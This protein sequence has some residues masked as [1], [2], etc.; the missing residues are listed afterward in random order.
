[1]KNKFLAPILCA[2]LATCALLPATLAHAAEDMAL[3]HD[4][5]RWYEEDN[6]P[7]ARLHNLNKETAAAYAEAL[8]ACRAMSGEQAATCRKQAVQA[9]QEDAARA[10]RIYH[11]YK[12]SLGQADKMSK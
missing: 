4:P 7:K 8:Q 10:L 2:L 1:M 5:A 3:Q 9:R 11:D 6:S 12:K